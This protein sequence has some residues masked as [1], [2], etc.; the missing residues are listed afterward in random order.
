M[1]PTTLPK[2][3][4]TAGNHLLTWQL[5]AEV[6]KEENRK[7]LFGKRGDQNSPAEHKI[8]VAKSIAA[9]VVPD[10]Y[11]LDATVAGD[12]VKSKIA[13]ITEQIERDWPFFPRFHRLLST[14]PNVLPVA[15]TTGVG[16][17][18]ESTVY[19][20]G[21][22]PTSGSQGAAQVITDDVIDPA[23]RSVDMNQVR[24]PPTPPPT[25]Q[26]LP[27]AS[28]SVPKTPTSTQATGQ[29]KLNLAMQKASASIKPLSKK[30][31]WEDSFMSITEKNMEL[32]Q[33]RMKEER[34]EKRAH[35]RIKEREQYLAEYREGLISRE[36]WQALVSGERSAS[37]GKHSA[38]LSPPPRRARQ[39]SP[40]WDIE[41]DD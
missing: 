31:T 38:S 23:L 2:I 37:L 25:Q 5:L 41:E 19:F 39:Q 1:A 4:W 35:L 11:A 3:N 36:E 7:V 12:R 29:D 34:E 10:L 27:P 6:E 40:R 22:P 9:A 21:R 20:Q 26:S 30:R 13:S 16:P 24:T 33:T 32:V 17:Q 14:R 28:A 15:I 18:G 8:S